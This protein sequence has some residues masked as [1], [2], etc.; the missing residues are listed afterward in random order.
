MG[1]RLLPRPRAAACWLV[2]RAITMTM[3]TKSKRIIT[4]TTI[5]MKHTN[6][7][8]ITIKKNFNNTENNK[9]NNDYHNNHENL[10]ISNNHTYNNNNE[11]RI[12]IIKTIIIIFITPIS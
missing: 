4:T 7:P 5:I 1:T 10:N 12:I 2:W 3:V 11:L 9:H 8:I 6:I